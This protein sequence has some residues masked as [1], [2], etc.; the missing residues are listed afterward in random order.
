[1]TGIKKSFFEERTAAQ[2][3]ELARINVDSI[4]DLVEA[5]DSLSAR[6]HVHISFPIFDKK[7]PA[8]TFN[9]YGPL[10]RL[11]HFE[12]A[13]QCMAAK[14]HPWEL[15]R[16]SVNSMAE[17]TLGYAD[18]PPSVDPDCRTIKSD[19]RILVVP[20]KEILEGARLYAYSHQQN[21]PITIDFQLT[22]NAGYLGK[23]VIGSV[24][25]RREKIARYNVSL[26]H[27]PALVITNELS[28]REKEI[29]YFVPHIMRPSNN[30]PKQRY[31]LLRSG[32]PGLSLNDVLPVMWA[33]IAF[34][35]EVIRAEKMMIDAFSAA[36][37]KPVHPASAEFTMFPIPTKYAVEL[38]K[39][40]L[41][42]ALNQ[43]GEK[44]RDAEVNLILG[45]AAK[46]HKYNKLF[47]AR[48]SVD[49]KLENYNWQPAK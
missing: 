42:N 35:Y 14:L 17:P 40:I 21:V 8:R 33:D 10:I 15:L 39:K 5:F 12:T 3:K 6:E 41:N 31:A 4:D 27:V 7:I 20:W 47:F 36:G 25:S 45:A 24:P 48:N 2:I 34:Y 22:E 9:K 44:P 11:Q 38:Y 26:S 28:D 43:K 29:Q 23:T 30:T 37:S 16:A 49:G 1:M 18:I 32:M 46:D 13:G 19:L